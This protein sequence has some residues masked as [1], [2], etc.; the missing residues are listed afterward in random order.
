MKGL[1]RLI[2][3]SYHALPMDV[4]SSYRAKAYCDHFVSYGVYPILVTH[5]WE[6]DE[7]GKWKYHDDD[8]IGR[9]HV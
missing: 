3:L 7:S 1:K 4:V 8:K 6:Q 2:I 5:R 9:A